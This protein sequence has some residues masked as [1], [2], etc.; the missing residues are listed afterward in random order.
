[1]TEA[2]KTALIT[3][4][5]GGLGR[6][7]AKALATDGINTAI[8]DSDEAGIPRDKM[9]KPTIMGP[10]IRWLAPPAS[11]G[12]TDRRFV[13]ASW[14]PDRSDAEAAR[15]AGAPIGWPELA[16]TVVWPD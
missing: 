13:A 7:M 9:L 14:D 2:S 4:G 11:D 16:K 1:M 10:P 15:V 6:V 8:F 5:T 3:G 12:V